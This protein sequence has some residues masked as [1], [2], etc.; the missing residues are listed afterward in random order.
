M[1]CIALLLWLQEGDTIGLM[2]TSLG[3]L[4][5]Y[6]NGEDQGPAAYNVPDQLYGIIGNLLWV[7]IDFKIPKYIS[8]N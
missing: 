8:F 2:R 7:Q 3:V 5:F 1:W 4:H 6:I